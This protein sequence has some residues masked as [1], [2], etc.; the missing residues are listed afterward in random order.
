MREVARATAP[1]LPSGSYLLRLSPEAGSQERA[2]F[3]AD[4]ATALSRAAGTDAVAAVLG[5]G[6]GAWSGAGVGAGTE[7]GSEPEPEQGWPT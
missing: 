2:R 6:V 5:A 4:V 3:R 1:S 7:P